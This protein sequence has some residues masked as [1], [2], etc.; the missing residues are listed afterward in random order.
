MIPQV[1]LDEFAQNAMTQYIVETVEERAIPEFKDGLKPVQRR[2]LWSMYKLG[3]YHDLSHKK[4][5]RVVGDVIGKYHPHGDQAAYQAI[6][7]LAQCSRKYNLVSG[8]GNW[9]S[10]GGDPA[11]SMRY[12][13]CKLSKLA[14]VALLD[15]QYLKVVPFVDNFDGSER[16]PVYLPAR[17]PFILLSGISGIA[18][19]VKTGIPCLQI[20][21]VIDNCIAYLKT[22][23]LSNFIFNTVGIFGG[24]SVA[25]QQEI[26]QYLQKGSGS[27]TFQP[28]F[29][30]FK[31]R[32]EITGVHDQF[33]MNKKIE[34]LENLAQ[35]KYVKDEGD[36]RIKIV[37]YLNCKIT[38]QPAIDKIVKTLQDPVQFSTNV[39]NRKLV[40]QKV[41]ANYTETNI[42]KLTENWCKFRI[43]LEKLHL[44]NLID[45]KNQE[46][47]QQN[48]LIFAADNSKKIFHCLQQPDP[49]SSLISTLK[50]NDR[51]AEIILNLQ[52]KRLSK[53]DSEQGKQNVIKMTE[54]L[55]SLQDKLNDIV[56]TVIEDL[57]YLKK[58]FGANAK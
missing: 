18:T 36:N 41:V 8:Q 19:A 16:E 37:I 33:N 7:G 48:L 14:Q 30:I 39:L 46:I 53:L 58:E 29:T 5:A 10:Y 25:D 13:E 12:T 34:A 11:A 22:K 56:N 9:G 44:N 20:D 50:L 26:D 52:V 35:V 24:Q 57:Q 42:V 15:R 47:D 55:K 54:Q 23:D 38:D 51:Q 40:G 28:D 4:S 32:I 2:A 49:K 6:V 43:H 17:L 21:S 27:I 3:L 45:Q 31:D 1:R